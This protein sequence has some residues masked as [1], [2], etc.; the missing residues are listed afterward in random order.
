MDVQLCAR[1]IKFIFEDAEDLRTISIFPFTPLSPLSH[2][3]LSIT[4]HS[5]PANFLYGSFSSLPDQSIG[6]T[7][8]SRDALIVNIRLGRNSESYTSGCIVEMPGKLLFA[9][10]LIRPGQSNCGQRLPI[11]LFFGLLGPT[12]WSSLGNASQGTVE[13]RHWYRD[14]ECFC[15][16]RVRYIWSKAL[17]YHV[18]STLRGSFRSSCVQYG[19]WPK[20]SHVVCNQSFGHRVEHHLYTGQLAVNSQKRQEQCRVDAIKNTT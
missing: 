10:W 17:Q 7:K 9:A 6:N 3:I 18:D 4:K 13:F 8:L 16:I 1:I 11:N 19:V 2:R 14:Y 12:P 20:V 15:T 5:P